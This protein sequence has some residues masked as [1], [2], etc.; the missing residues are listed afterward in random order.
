MQANGGK[1]DAPV[2]GGQV[3]VPVHAQRADV[4]PVKG[5]EAALL[6]GEVDTHGMIYITS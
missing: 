3:D 1:P 5:A 2:I 6:L 4:G